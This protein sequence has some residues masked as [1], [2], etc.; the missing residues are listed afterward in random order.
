MTPNQRRI[1]LFFLCGVL[2]A[3][4]LLSASLSNLQLHPGLPIPGGRNAGPNFS[5]FTKD[6]PTYSP[7]L[8][9]VRGL[10]ALLFLGLMI[11][12]PIR[13]LALINFKRALQW[14]IVI[15]V[16][17]ILINVLAQI[18]PTSTSRFSGEAPQATIPPTGNISVT[19]LGEPPQT[20][21]WIVLGILAIGTGI[22]L[23]RIFKTS[24]TPALHTDQLSQEAEVAMHAIRL[25][26]DLR[27]VIIRC[28][29]QMT[30]VI[31]TER[32]VERNIDMT[33]REFE[34]WLNLKGFPPKPVNQ[35]T[36]LFERARYDQRALTQEDENTALESLQAIVLFC[37]NEKD[38][39]I[40]A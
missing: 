25:G 5:G 4:V 7:E 29:L 16:L 23:F 8:S 10:L 30:H 14:L 17:L 36:R 38:A 27:E 34:N 31:Q 37:Q 33:V 2:I 22:L 39:V 32:K 35:L 11:Y 24:K 26:E 28:Y 15:S 3:V 18:K 1:G 6:T 20:F 12:L 13:L 21:I 19:A 40:R 9:L